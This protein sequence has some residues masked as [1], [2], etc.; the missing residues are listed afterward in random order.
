[1]VMRY[2]GNDSARDVTTVNG[3]PQKTGEKQIV[4]EKIRIAFFF[5]VVK[6][7]QFQSFEGTFV[8]RPFAWRKVKWLCDSERSDSEVNMVGFRWPDLRRA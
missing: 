4:S 6:I 5:C 1:M 7:C 2:E 3:D 8:D